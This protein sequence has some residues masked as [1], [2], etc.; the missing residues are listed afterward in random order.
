VRNL[1]RSLV[2]LAAFALVMAACGDDASILSDGETTVASTATT[3]APPATTEALPATTE[4][5][6]ATTEA[7]P[8]TTEAPPETTEAPP[9]TTE[10]PPETTEAPPDT[11]EPA[12]MIPVLTPFDASESNDDPPLNMMVVI[13]IVSNVPAAAADAMNGLISTEKLGAATSF[14][15][16]IVGGDPPPDGT[17][18]ELS[19]GYEATAVTAG[20]LSLRFDLYMYYQG[21]AHGISGIGTMNFDPQTGALLTL[22]D[23]LVP[24]TFPAAASLVEQALIDQLYGGDAAEASSWL[25]SIDMVLLDGW[26]VTP[27]GL[28][29]SF[30]QYEVGFGAM[31][32]PTVVVP[33]GALAALI[34]PNG[35]AAPFAFGA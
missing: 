13:P 8:E 15:D 18:S 9:E 20:L 2:L 26:V 23:I 14:R 17:S 28:A 30:D 25:P 1:S 22:P 34:D 11:T 31:G 29:F 21:A 24:G 4:V 6:P 27:A 5:P 19:L 33:W 16:E 35:P 32:S 10:A 7:P 3:A 12:P